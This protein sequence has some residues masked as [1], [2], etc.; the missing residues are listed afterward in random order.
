MQND[1]NFLVMD[2]PTN[3][4]DIPSR[5][6]IEEAVSQFD[7]TIMFISHDRYFI[8]KFATRVWEMEQGA[9]MDYHGSFQEYCVWK[10]NHA[11]IGKSLPKDNGS[12]NKN[13]EKLKPNHLQNR[14]QTKEDTRHKKCMDIESR[15]TEE[16]SRLKDICTEMAEAASDFDKLNS[17]Y[18][19]KIE[20]EKNIEMLYR[21]WDELNVQ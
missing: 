1:C 20:M 11:E 18:S 16:E 12:K 17:L 7:G 4:L 15:I 2:E 19:E 8:N 10:Q 14:E 6:W 21:R 9:I 5:E 3:H 13:V